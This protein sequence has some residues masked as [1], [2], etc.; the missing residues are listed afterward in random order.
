MIRLG[1]GISSRDIGNSLARDCGSR[2]FLA[3]LFLL[4]LLFLK[5]L[6]VQ[7]TETDERIVDEGFHDGQKGLF[8]L[9]HDSDRVFAGRSKV[10]L[11]SGDLHRSDEHSSQSERNLLRELLAAHRDFKAIAEVDMDNPTG[12]ALEHDVRRMTITQA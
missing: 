2:Y 11:D 9:T 8:L 6:G 10:A 1:W 7:K 4:L 12:V 5:H 3:D